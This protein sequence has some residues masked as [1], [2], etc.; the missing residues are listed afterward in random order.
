MKA[1]L[2]NTGIFTAGIFTIGVFAS[3]IF[4]Q[5]KLLSGVFTAGG[6]TEWSLYLVV[7]VGLNPTSDRNMS[8]IFF[9]TDFFMFFLLRNTKGVFINHVF[10]FLAL[11]IPLFPLYRIE[12]ALLNE[13]AD[14]AVRKQYIPIVGIKIRKLK[15]DLNMKALSRG[16]RNKH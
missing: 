12:V 4:I 10:V 11:F 14:S 7:S 13:I 3:D 6:I 8:I 15:M 5:S 2:L 1:L 9:C 16:C